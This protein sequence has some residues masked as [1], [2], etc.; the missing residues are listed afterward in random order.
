MLIVTA[1]STQKCIDYMA[2]IEVSEVDGIF[3]TQ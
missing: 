1:K 3:N 2:R